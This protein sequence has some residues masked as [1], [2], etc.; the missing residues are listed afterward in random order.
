MNA[1]LELEQV[2]DEKF[3]SKMCLRRSGLRRRGV[4]FFED[5]DLST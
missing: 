2:Q 4:R 5:L 1:K 3:K